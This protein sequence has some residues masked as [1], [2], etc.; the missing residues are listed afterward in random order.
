VRGIGL[1]SGVEIVRPGTLE[2]DAGTARAIVE[3]M[4]ERGVLI[5]TTGRDRNALKIRPPLAVGIPEVDLVVDA[6]ADVLR[7]IGSPG[8]Q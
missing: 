5:G 2:P 1:A 3:G 6:L 7:S 4:R 8:G